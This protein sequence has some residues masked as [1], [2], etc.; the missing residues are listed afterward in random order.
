MW[1]ELCVESEDKHITYYLPCMGDSVV[2]T[3]TSLN[4]V[5]FVGHED[6]F[7]SVWKSGNL[8]VG[9][10]VHLKDAIVIQPSCIVNHLQHLA[11]TVHK[12]GSSRINVHALSNVQPLYLTKLFTGLS[13]TNIIH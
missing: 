12:I 5:L 7:S 6:D 8:S 10:S 2:C 13:S 9:K 11:C 3:W 4:V 1:K